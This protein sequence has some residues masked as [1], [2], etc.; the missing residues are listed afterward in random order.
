MAVLASLNDLCQEICPW[1]FH[2][3]KATILRPR[4]SWALVL[5]QPRNLKMFI[6]L[7]IEVE[8]R[9]KNLTIWQ[10]SAGQTTCHP[11][12]VGRIKMH[13]PLFMHYVQKLTW[14]VK[15]LST[16]VVKQWCRWGSR[17]GCTALM[18]Y[19][20]KDL[21]AEITVFAFHMAINKSAV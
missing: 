18:L 2:V 8:C 5:I 14:T 20:V 10:A 13:A 12:R 16:L 17:T 11:L 19:W 4:S 1:H 7:R 21:C 6:H 15:I 9:K 3:I